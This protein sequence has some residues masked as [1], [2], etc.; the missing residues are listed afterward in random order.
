MSM[1]EGESDTSTSLEEQAVEALAA[2]EF[3][4]GD[5]RE[6]G[7]EGVWLLSSS[8]QGFSVDALRD[9]NPDTF[10]QSDGPQPHL[11]TV[12]FHRRML[13]SHVSIF[14]S[15]SN[16]ESY[17]PNK[18]SVRVGSSINDLKELR[19]VD[20]EQVED[21]RDVSL[22]VSD[23]PYAGFVIQVAILTNHQNGRDSHL[24]GV[25]VFSPRPRLTSPLSSEAPSGFV[26]RDFLQYEFLR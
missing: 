21:W 19:V 9:D 14:A 8:K 26:T 16:D 6:V 5:V 24:R 18:I 1:S 15:F 2:P 7:E 23:Q 12:Q 25:R 13:F 22:Y 3:D 17:T 10:W 4:F 20:F 11:I